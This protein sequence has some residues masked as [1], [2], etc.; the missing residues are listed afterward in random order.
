MPELPEVETIKRGLLKTIIGKRIVAVRIFEKKSARPS[1]AI[2]KRGLVGAK[3]LSI[4]RKGKYLIFL[5][6]S[7]KEMIAHLRMTG[8]LVFLP[9][10]S[11][12]VGRATSDEKAS[13]RFTRIIVE[14][15]DGSRLNFNDLRKFGY[16]ELTDGARRE[17][18]LARVGEDIL[19]IG[20]VGFRAALLRRPKAQIKAVLLDQRFFS[21]IG[22]IYAD[23]ILH[24]AGVLPWRTVGD[25]SV[26]EIKK[27]YLAAKRIL[28][29][30]VKLGGTS[31]SDYVDAA[32]KP[33]RYVKELKVYQRHGKLCPKCRHKIKK[34]RI[35]GRGTHYCEKCQK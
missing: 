29:R 18:I 26:I 6:N 25:L 17:K 23:E 1:P 15:A 28:A 8:Q 7:G 9:K 31:Y 32:G 14:F 10:I 21:G 2:L 19:A 22:N 3:F 11:L 12:I 4:T 16:L 5:L 13:D 30:A 34:I 20:F 35:A 24:V 33:G 27:I